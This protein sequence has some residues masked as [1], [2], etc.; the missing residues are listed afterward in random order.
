MEQHIFHVQGM[1][2]AHCERAVSA[3][4]QGL[5]AQAQTAID[6]AAC[7]VQIRSHASRS[8][9]AAAIAQLGYAVEESAA[10]PQR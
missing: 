7:R 3:A 6:R 8:A 1:H 4:V 9:L 2:C 5:D 10:A